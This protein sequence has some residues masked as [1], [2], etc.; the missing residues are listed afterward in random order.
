M[1]KT[2]Y[3]LILDLDGTISQTVNFPTWYYDESSRHLFP[4]VGISMP[5]LVN[6]KE[7]SKKPSTSPDMRQV[8]FRPYLINFLEYC[9]KTFN[10]SIW[11][12]NTEEY[13]IP[14][15][16]FLEI[17]NK[18]KH[19]WVKK[20]KKGKRKIKR[21]PNGAFLDETPQQQFEYE[22]IKSKKK[23][24][25]EMDYRATFKPLNILWHQSEFSRQ[26]NPNNTFIID[27]MAEMFVQFPDNTILIPTWC[28]LNWS[29]ANLKI[30][31]DQLEI[32]FNK[33]RKSIKDMT[34]TINKSFRK[35]MWQNIDSAS[36]QFTDF[37][38]EIYYTKSIT[39]KNQKL[40]LKQEKLGNIKVYG[41]RG[42]KSKKKP[43]KGNKNTRKKNKN[44]K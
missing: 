3:N 18:C 20:F 11:S 1:I 2:K 28:H 42:K 21:I 41:K 8:F 25:L 16:E 40:L 43:V 26:Y 36:C 10:V 30:I 39:K 17:K 44:R 5:L 7:I 37:R 22:E 14:I 13:T 32:Y 27:D 9:F 24:K 15:L 31:I 33:K 34:Y 29:D 12:N 35:D 4:L 38:P 19:I 6:K 23:I